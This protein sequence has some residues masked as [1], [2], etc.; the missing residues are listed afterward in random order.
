[1]SQEYI[2]EGLDVVYEYQ[3]PSQKDIVVLQTTQF[4]ES[5]KYE[6]KFDFLF[7]GELKSPDIVVELM[8]KDGT[9]V[10]ALPKGSHESTASKDDTR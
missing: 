5:T 2:L 4:V 8:N 9:D 1:M 3:Q 10:D 6:C 7:S